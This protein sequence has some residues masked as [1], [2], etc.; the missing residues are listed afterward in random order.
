MLQ[1]SFKA[2]QYLK[3]ELNLYA[4]KQTSGYITSTS[5]QI[6]TFLYCS[7][8]TYVKIGADTRR[9]APFLPTEDMLISRS[10]GCCLILNFWTQTK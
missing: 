3:Y 5:K 2:D 9:S 1:H 8:K 4:I 10:A 6:L 7:S